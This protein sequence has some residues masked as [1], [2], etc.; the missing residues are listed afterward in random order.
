[1]GNRELAKSLIDQI[2]DAKLLYVIPFLQG[3]SLSDEMPN[4]ETLEAMAEVQA[5][6]E[7]SAGEHF[8]GSTSDFLAMLSEE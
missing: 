7:S 2:S 8:N 6:I 5:M 4:A 3:A 1:M